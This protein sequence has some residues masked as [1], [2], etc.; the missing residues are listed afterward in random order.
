MEV[1]NSKLFSKWHPP[2]L[3]WFLPVFTPR[4]LGIFLDG[5][6]SMPNFTSSLSFSG[7][8]YWP[9][10]S[11]LSSVAPSSKYE[12]LLLEK[13]P[14]LHHQQHGQV[15]CKFEFHSILYN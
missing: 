2:F 14:K 6:S 11:Q 9:S 10:P 13:H 12:Q 3:L 5:A 8:K 4:I 1:E 15:C 7:Y